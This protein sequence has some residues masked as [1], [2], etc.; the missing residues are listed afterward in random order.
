MYPIV[1]GPEVRIL[2][3]DVESWQGK[4]ENG[5]IAIMKQVHRNAPGFQTLDISDGAGPIDVGVDISFAESEVILL[6]KH[7][8]HSVLWT[9]A[10]KRYDTGKQLCCGQVN[11]LQKFHNYIYGIRFLVGT[12]TDTFV[13]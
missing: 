2:W 12:D 9:R 8:I 4:V 6:Q 1:T 7:A 3:K 13:Q 5:S 10:K 11:G